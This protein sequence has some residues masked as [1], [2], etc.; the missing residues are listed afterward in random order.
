M[1]FDNGERHTYTSDQLR[2][3]FGFAD[4]QPARA[5]EFDNGER[6][7][8]TSK[9]LKEQFGFTDIQPGTAVEH[10]NQHRGTATKNKMVA[11]AGEEQ[12][13]LLE[14]LVSEVRGNG[15]RQVQVSL[16]HSVP[17]SS[18]HDMFH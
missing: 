2:E 5:V 12:D 9:Q 11:E 15:K 16:Q 3:K 18:R 7:A 10:S 17:D 4:I 6:H 14:Q 8:Y 1:E 13:E